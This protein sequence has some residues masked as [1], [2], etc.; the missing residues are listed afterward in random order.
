MLKEKVMHM[1]YYVHV[2]VSVNATIF[3]V[4]YGFKSEL[5]LAVDFSEQTFE[6]II[7]HEN[8]FGF[9]RFFF[10]DHVELNEDQ[11]R[12]TV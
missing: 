4:T 7:A 10:E 2:F 12:P 8:M 3:Q 9:P 11:M 6:N 5:T 1:I